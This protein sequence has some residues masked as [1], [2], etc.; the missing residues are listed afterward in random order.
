[1]RGAT[2]RAGRVAVAASNRSSAAIENRLPIDARAAAKCK[3]GVVT[4]LRR[5]NWKPGA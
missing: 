3:P 2:A 1:M 4:S 5:R